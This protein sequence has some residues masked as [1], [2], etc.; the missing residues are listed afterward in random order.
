[1]KMIYPN[2]E[3]VTVLKSISNE[4]EVLTCCSQMGKK[5]CAEDDYRIS[6]V[7]SLLWEDESDSSGSSSS[8]DSRDSSDSLSSRVSWSPTLVDK[9]HYRP[10]ISHNEKDKLFYSCSDYITFRRLYKEHLIQVGIKRRRKSKKLKMQ[11]DQ[12]EQS[13]KKEEACHDISPL[14][15]L[16]N[17]V[18]IFFST[19]S[20]GHHTLRENR[21]PTRRAL[22]IELLVDTL[23]LF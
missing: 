20:S 5:S 15:W 13:N 23:Y 21:K 18:Q 10:T 1:M 14:T 8:L 17:N 22:D 11:K 16:A 9:V 12:P 3:K 4:D 19:E 2:S 6:R 7:P